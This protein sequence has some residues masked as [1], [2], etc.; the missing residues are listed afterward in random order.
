MRRDAVEGGPEATDEDFYVLRSPDWVNVVA[1][2]EDDQL[3]LIEQ[4]RY[5]VQR[6][7]LEIAGGMV[8]AGESPVAAAARELLEETGYAAE[9]WLRL[10][11]IDPN[12]A[13]LDNSC[14]SFAALGCRRIREPQFDRREHC[15][16]VL[17]PYERVI[18]LVT[19]GR[20]CHALVVVALHYESLRRAGH[21]DAEPVEPT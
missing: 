9:R 10:G 16:L 19:S 14:Y 8:D 3:V 13:I 4:F 11:R 20:I 6:V 15:A 21:L 18:E 17:E 1:L 2:T 7:T 12:P 5:G